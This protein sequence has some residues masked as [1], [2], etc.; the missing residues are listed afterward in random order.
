MASRG[1][2]NSSKAS[3]SKIGLLKTLAIRRGLDPKAVL[4]V[5]R[6]EGLSG[7]VGDQGTSF[8]PFQLHK[9][10]ALPQGIPLASA[11]EWAWSPAG[12]NYALSK[13]ASVAGGL[14]GRAA[15]ENIVR[16]FERPANPDREV[17]GALAAYG[18]A[19][20]Q[21]VIPNPLGSTDPLSLG[22]PIN[23]NPLLKAVLSGATDLTGVIRQ[24]HSLG[25]NISPVQ[26]LPYQKGTPMPTQNLP[27]ALASTLPVEL[28]KEGVGGPTHSTGR[29]IH[30]AYTNPQ[31][32]LA[33][34]RL[35][36][37]LGLAVRENPY[38]ESVDP[39]HAKN[40]YHYRVFP[41]VYGG[42]KLGEAIDVSGPKMDLFYSLLSRLS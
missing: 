18:G 19:P 31:A 40:S 20:T 42:R 15:V 3:Q 34:I 16:R 6:Q 28:L 39:V 32:M 37:S 30:V 33:A 38:T 21:T 26:P 5:A 14:K 36:Q 10:G 1:Q 35:A 9:G 24:E 41:G 17:A 13:I 8:G 23:S 2:I 22:A 27:A 12:L 4:A 25:A 29:H 7:G 11:Q